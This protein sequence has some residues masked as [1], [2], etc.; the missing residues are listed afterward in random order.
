MI[1]MTIGYIVDIE[2]VWG[3]QCRVAGLSKT[4]PSF[5]YPPPT[6]FLGALSEAIAKSRKIGEKEGPK[7]MSAL[8]NCLLGIGWRPLNCTVIKYED[9]NRLIMIARSRGKLT[10]D[11][12]RLEGSFDSPARGKTVIVSLNDEPP[13]V[14]WTIVFKGNRINIEGL[15]IEFNENDFWKIHRLG[16]KES[17]VS[18]IGVRSIKELSKRTNRVRT[19]NS[20]FIKRGEVEIEENRGRWNYE[21]YIEPFDIKAYSFKENPFRYYVCLLYTSPSPR[22]LSTSRMPSSA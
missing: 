17:I 4:S 18:V 7:I 10:P 13:V 8:S 20:F 21:V 19:K 3:F 5:Y 22:D 2:F 6:T 12:K 15:S 16:S 1:T 11:P 9:I 14:R